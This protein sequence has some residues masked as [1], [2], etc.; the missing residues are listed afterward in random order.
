MLIGI[1]ARFY[2]SIGKGLGR[3]TQKLIENLEKTD[4][5][6]RYVVF[7]RKENFDEYQPQNPNFKKVLADY[8]WYSFA[9]QLFFPRL[10]RKYNF[11]FVHFP[12]FNVPLLYRKKFIMTI[13]D[14]ILIHFPT[15]RS[16]TLSPIF[17]WIKF[18]A[19]KIVIRSA[20]YRSEKIIAVSNFTKK[21]ILSV[22]K[23]IPENKVVVTYEGCDNQVDK[24]PKNDEEVLQF[25]GIMKPY[26]IYVGN[27]YP[28]KNPERLVLAFKEVLEH[29]KYIALVFVGGEDYFYMRL[30]KF[31]AEKGI[32]NVIFAGFVL[33]G[34]MNVLLRNS[35]AY[36]RPSLYE[37]FELPP[38]EAMQQ[39]VPVLCSEH[40]C[41][42]EVLGNSALYFNGKNIADI[43]DCV[44]KILDNEKLRQELIAKGYGQI[45]KYSWE[46]TG[47]ETL[48]IYKNIICR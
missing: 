5:E 15:V 16:S 19:Y 12:H 24:L 10:L 43:R 7:L 26:I 14:L 30:K 6:N 38:L 22:Y 36:V 20:I 1:D 18:L 32:K 17:Y 47:R 13:H 46:R 41:A 8:R 11:D 27:V 3:Y 25:Y 34:E 44:L 29:K 40:G 35:Q 45:K 21:D 39:G 33:D 42:R 37:G 28:H 9:E 23:N 2:G 4:Q 31:V 48:E